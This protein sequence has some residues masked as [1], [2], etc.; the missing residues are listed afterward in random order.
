[1]VG[2][3]GQAPLARPDRDPQG[4]PPVV[5]PAAAPAVPADETLRPPP[6]AATASTTAVDADDIEDLFAPPHTQPRRFALV[7]VTLSILTW[8]IAFT[9]GAWGTV[10]Y[11]KVFTVW[12]ASLALLL[13]ALFTPREER[14]FH[15]FDVFVFA[16]PTVWIGF[17]AAIDEEWLTTTPD[18]LAEFVFDALFLL[19]GISIFVVGIPYLL[20]T[21]LD[22]LNPDATQLTGD[23][24]RK[25]FGLLVIVAAIALFVGFRND[26]FLTCDAFAV[27]G[28]SMPHNCRSDGAHPLRDT[29]LY[30]IGVA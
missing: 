28:D 16:L 30:L 21:L 25:V 19:F 3:D 15:W 18:T 29:L 14:R 26:L 7:A 8:D 22:M 11:H 4:Q 27:A 2:T 9:L 20:K 6:I 12:A 24:R 13:V 17:Y 5:A 23:Q 10:F 1:M